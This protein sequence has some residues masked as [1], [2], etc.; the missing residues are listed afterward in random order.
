MTWIKLAILK[1]N[2]L[3][4]VM[5]YARI[6]KGILWRMCSWDYFLT[7]VIFLEAHYIDTFEESFCI[8]FFEMMSHIFFPLNKEPTSTSMAFMEIEE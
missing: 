7:I 2:F 3:R 8:G 6:F 4:V 1:E 5:D